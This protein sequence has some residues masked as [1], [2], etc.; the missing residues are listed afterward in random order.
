MSP[1][2]KSLVPALK[3]L[4]TTAAEVPAVRISSQRTI[5]V[6]EK[7]KTAKFEI[8]DAFGKPFKGAQN[9][10]VSLLDLSDNKAAIKDIT[11]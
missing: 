5:S 10:K 6:K 4:Q 1:N 8:V 2:V 11:S 7:T 9:V 3:G